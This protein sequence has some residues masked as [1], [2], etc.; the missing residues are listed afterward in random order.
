[1]LQFRECA[2]RM[3]L[4]QP[5]AAAHFLFIRPLYLFQYS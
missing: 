5:N 3:D 1:M 2:E 4:T